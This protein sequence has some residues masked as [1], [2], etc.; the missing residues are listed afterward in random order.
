MK[1]LTTNE[2][3]L[4]MSIWRLKDEAYGVKIRKMFCGYTGTDVGFG[5]LY[6]NI[7]QLVKKGYVVS[8]K[9]EPTAKRGGKR[10]VYYKIT[11]R[12]LESLQA[13]HALHNKLWEGIVPGEIRRGE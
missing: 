3:I 13:A 1:R 11:N 12:G 4:L 10:K 9:G 5:T 8:F 7:D 2:E 6:N